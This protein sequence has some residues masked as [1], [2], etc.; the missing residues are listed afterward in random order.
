VHAFAPHSIQAI[1]TRLA[2]HPE[3]LPLSERAMEIIMLGGAVD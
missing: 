1:T 3:R 2:D